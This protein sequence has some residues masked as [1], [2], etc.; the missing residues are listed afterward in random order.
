MM[1]PE[2]YEGLREEARA[3]A[4]GIVEITRGDPESLPSDVAGRV[5][6]ERALMQSFEV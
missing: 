1:W 2:E 3:M 6:A 4:A 5:A